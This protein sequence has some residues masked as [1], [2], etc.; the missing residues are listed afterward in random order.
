M[1]S[2]P[3]YHIQNG[4]QALMG[5]DRYL[6]VWLSSYLPEDIKERC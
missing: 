3:Y 2:M 6:H 1:P 5:F 4:G